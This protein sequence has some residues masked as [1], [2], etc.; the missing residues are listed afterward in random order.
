MTCL[1]HLLYLA[2]TALLALGLLR[3]RKILRDAE[4]PDTV[5][6]V[7]VPKPGLP[8]PHVLTDDQLFDRLWQVVQR[9]QIPVLPKTWGMWD[10]NHKSPNYGKDSAGQYDPRLKIIWLRPDFQRN[11]WVLAHE[12]GHHSLHAEGRHQHSEAEADDR[13]RRLLLS[14]LSAEEGTAAMWRID[15]YL[16][17]LS[18]GEQPP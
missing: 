16:P 6:L 15:I 14:V 12:L 8:P 10:T 3:W 1:P 9:E 13:G 18:A 5:K 17:A 7:D 4:R 2:A 11:P